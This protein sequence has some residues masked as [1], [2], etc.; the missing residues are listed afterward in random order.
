MIRKTTGIILFPL[1]S[2][3]ELTVALSILKQGNHPITT[4]G[5]TSDPITG[6]SDLTCL[7]DITIYDVEIKT[8]DSLLIPGCMDITTLF[9]K[10]DLFAFLRKC[11]AFNKDMI[12]GA[13]SSSPYLL[14]RSGILENREYT[15]G[16]HSR[17]R[18]QT[19]VFDEK[20]YCNELVV[21]DGNVLTARGRGFIEFGYRF[22]ELLNLKFNAD[23]YSGDNT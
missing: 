8:L 11:V 9:G 10:E 21:Q 15:V 16:M 14:A 2:E 6:E 7:T 17:H 4:I 12:I 22:G 19:G 20:N 23:W 3:Y 5:L 1:F 18:E 13:I